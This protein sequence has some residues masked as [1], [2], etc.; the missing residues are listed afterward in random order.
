M[1]GYEMFGEEEKM[2]VEEVMSRGVLFRYG[3]E[4]Q[5]KGV[6]K[7]KEFEEK[8]ADYIGTK[9][10]HA[11]SSG[12]AALRV[13]LFALN[14]G[15]GDEVI[16]S[17][18][19]FVATVEAILESGATPVIANINETLNIDPADLEQKISK[20]TKVVIPVHMMGVSA[21]MNEIMKI[22]KEHNL[23]VLEDSAQACGGSY[24]GKKLGAIGDIGIFSFDS[25]KTPTT[26]EGGMIVTNNEEYYLRSSWFADHGHHHVP[27]IPRGEDT[28]SV[29][30]FNYRMTELQGAIGIAQLQKLDKML[31]MQRENKKRIK[32]GIEG[33][34]DFKF[35]SLPDPK[36]DCGDSLVVIFPTVKKAKCVADYLRRNNITPKILPDALGWH[37]FGHWPHIY[38]KIRKYQRRQHELNKLFRQT[39]DILHRSVALPISIKMDDLR[40]NEIIETFKKA[41]ASG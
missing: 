8:F 37:Y 14:V 24:F 11:V 32:K 38:S 23:H 5:R 4:Q 25:F 35:R 33:T 20:K 18:F 16:T 41:V 40:I 12:S 21:Q 39:D 2:A 17:A 31:A 28:K 3:F 13:A 22:C 19:T 9:Y 10:A 34:G 27:G 36:G 29:F 15:P 6:F 1:P 7:V 30:G 26:G